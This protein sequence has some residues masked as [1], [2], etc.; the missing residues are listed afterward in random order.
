MPVS[1]E[2]YLRL[3]QEDPDHVWELHCG[4]LWSRPPMTWEHGDTFFELGYMLRSQLS[5]EEYIV[6][7]VH[8]RLRRS[9]TQY[10]VPDLVV[11]PAEMAD[12]LFARE[13]AVEIYP[14]PLPLVVEVW[15]PSTGRLDITEKL[16]EYQRRGDR[17]IWHLHP[18]QHTLTAWVR[19]PDGQYTETVYRRGIVRP[20]VFPHVAIDLDALFV[21]VRRR[22]TGA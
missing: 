6:H 7:V 19:R 20:T 4:H 15:S 1:E 14:E 16:P 12:R 13:G 11:V 9:E 18:Y 5:R 22:G 8:G 21:T 10:Y 3:I 2:T 17:E